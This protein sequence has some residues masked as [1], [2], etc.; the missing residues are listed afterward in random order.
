MTAAFPDSHAPR[1]NATNT[2]GSFLCTR[3][4]GSDVH[5]MILVNGE[6]GSEVH[7]II[8]VNE[9]PAVKYTK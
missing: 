6:T 3:E 1:A 7:K 4:T 8:P 5:K 2:L 9:K